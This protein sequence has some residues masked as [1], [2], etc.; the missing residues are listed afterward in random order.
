MNYFL[1]GDKRKLCY[2][3]DEERLV[4]FRYDSTTDRFVASASE[5]QDIRNGF[6]PFGRDG[7]NVTENDIKIKQISKEEAE[8]FMGRHFTQKE[9]DT[10]LITIKKI[11]D[12][13]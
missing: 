7:L 5:L 9:N 10:F 3:E 12:F 8:A 2:I 11:K 1:L 6:N 13:C 4:C